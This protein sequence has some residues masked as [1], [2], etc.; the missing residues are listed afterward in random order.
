[1]YTDVMPHVD[2][3]A[4]NNARTQV[5][6]T[7][8]QIQSFNNLIAAQGG[9]FWTKPRP[10]MNSGNEN[11]SKTLVFQNS[12]RANQLIWFPITV[13]HY[14]KNG[15]LGPLCKQ[16]KSI[17]DHVQICRLSLRLQLYMTRVAYTMTP[18]TPLHKASNCRF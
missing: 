16:E 14:T 2:T 13:T 6:H 12:V 11:T 18:S 8:R 3:A 9:F 4:L 7:D 10:D 1:M 15:F 17:F 5:K